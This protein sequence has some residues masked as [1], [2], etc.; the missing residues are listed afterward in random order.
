MK[1]NRIDKLIELL[2]QFEKEKK[3]WYT[4]NNIDSYDN[5]VYWVDCDWET[6]ITMYSD[7]YSKYYWFI[8]RLV[9]NDKIDYHKISDIMIYSQWRYTWINKTTAQRVDENMS[10]LLIM[11]LSIQDNPIEFLVSI[12]K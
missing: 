12:L 8:K 1:E 7:L 3:S 5:C 10:D 6:E 9:E 4:W 2:N 11:L